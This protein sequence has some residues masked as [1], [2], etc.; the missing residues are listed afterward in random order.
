MALWNVVLIFTKSCCF[1]VCSTSL[2]FA[3]PARVQFPNYPPEWAQAPS[4][5]NDYPVKFMGGRVVI[6]VNPWV[7]KERLGLYKAIITETHDFFSS[8]GFNN[9]GNI[10]WGLP[11]QFG[12]QRTSGR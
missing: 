8:W 1:L 3:A 12:W 5:L 6:A 4:S 2:S 9:T 11:L 7:Y 10:L